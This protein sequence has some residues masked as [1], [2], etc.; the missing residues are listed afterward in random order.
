M[1][2]HHLPSYRRVSLLRPRSLLMLFFFVF[3]LGFFFVYLGRVTED[4][5]QEYNQLLAQVESSHSPTQDTPYTAK[6]ERHSIQKDLF[7]HRGAQ[8]LHIV[9]TAVDAQL[10][11]DHQD[12]H[13][14]I[15]EHMQ[16]V[17]CLMQEEL[18][19]ILPD[20][21]EYT[22]QPNGQLLLR[23]AD[24]KDQASWLSAD[25][26]GLKPMTTIR[27]IDADEA[28]YHYK[29]DRFVAYAVNIT[30]YTI[31]G[32]QSMMNNQ[33]KLLMK[34]KADKVEFS[35][36]AKEKDLDFKAHHLKATFFDMQG[37]NR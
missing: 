31:P 6:Q 8:R 36:K 27:C 20:G 11:L 15:V 2:H 3:V 22:P 32:H 24:E 35:M 26:P 5:T 18:Y 10:V 29:D 25:T 4:V 14:Y 28:E 37:L 34:G 13:T 9:L 12:A 1:S 19:Y 16:K 17:K 7:F 30:R 23:E 33:A 21:K